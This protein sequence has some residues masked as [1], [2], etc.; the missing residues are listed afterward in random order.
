[1]WLLLMPVRQEWTYLQQIGYLGQGKIRRAS[2][3]QWRSIWRGDW[4]KRGELR[5]SAKRITCITNSVVHAPLDQR[6]AG[7]RKETLSDVLPFEKKNL[8]CYF[9]SAFFSLRPVRSSKINSQVCFTIPLSRETWFM[10]CSPRF[11]H[12]GCHNTHAYLGMFWCGTTTK[13]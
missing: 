6:L 3:K 4:A 12:S 11:L 7:V 2:S 1:M 9:L 5:S 10:S 8:S 13:V